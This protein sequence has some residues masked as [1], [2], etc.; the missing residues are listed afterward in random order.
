MTGGAWYYSNRPAPPA[1]KPVVRATPPPAPTTTFQPPP[2]TTLPPES[3][4]TTAPLSVAP[5]GPPPSTPP[6]ARP[7]PTPKPTPKAT[8]AA[9]SLAEVRQLLEQRDYAAAARG[10]ASSVRSSTDARFTVQLL[11]ACSDETVGKALASASGSELFILPVNYKG[12]SCYRLC[13]GLYDGEGRANSALGS[14][15]TYFREGGAK[16]KVSPTA[17]LLP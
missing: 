9:G 2:S 3:L 17:S 15:P 16:P 1:L 7:T 13:W 6:P 5:S 8:A 14:L 11:V 4:A 12:K 10:F